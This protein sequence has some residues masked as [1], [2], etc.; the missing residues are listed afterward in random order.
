MND[1]RRGPLFIIMYVATSKF[2]PP[3]SPRTR[4]G[5]PCSDAADLKRSSTVADLL[6]L[7][8]RKA[9]TY[10]AVNHES[11]YITNHKPSCRTRQL[12]HE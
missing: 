4:E 5:M 2:S 8:A 6:L 3:R 1:A 11:V 9:V 7:L 10:E 12:L